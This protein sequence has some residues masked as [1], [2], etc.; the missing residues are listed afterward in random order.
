MTRI[1]V[2]C[3][4]LLASAFV[5][6]GLLAV[7]LSG[8]TESTAQAGLVLNKDSFT[9]LTAHTRPDEEALFV[10]DSLN[11]KLLVYRVDIARNRI[12]LSSVTDLRQMFAGAAGGG[13]GA[14]RAPR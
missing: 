6:A 9:L 1:Q 2:A 12:E 4:A 7:S 11:E 5:L 14:G 3:C 8:R 10:I 13:A